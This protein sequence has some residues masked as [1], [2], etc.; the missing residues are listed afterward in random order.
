MLITTRHLLYPGPH[1]KCC[2]YNTLFSLLD[3]LLNKARS[4]IIPILQLRK[5]NAEGVSGLLKVT[6][7]WDLNPRT[8]LLKP[9]ASPHTFQM[10]K[11]QNGDPSGAWAQHLGV[12]ALSAS[13]SAI[14]TSIVS[15]PLHNN[16]EW[17]YNLHFRMWHL[18]ISDLL[19]SRRWKWEPLIPNPQVFSLR[20]DPR[21]FC[22]L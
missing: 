6:Q 10:W 21:S 11:P 22:L 12:V 19:S 17:S 15:L 13:S 1:A 20:C 16:C 3:N 9:S 18:E 4:I 14:T 8:L 7:S 5:L 2:I